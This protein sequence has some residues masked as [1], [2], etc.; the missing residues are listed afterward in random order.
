MKLILDA[1][2]IIF[3]FI[4]YKFFGL[5]TATKVTIAVAII[6]ILLTRIIVGKFEK[7]TIISALC[8]TILG[9][10][11]LFF[12]NEIFIK[13]KPTAVY[14]ASAVAF[15]VTHFLDKTL[16]E[17]I[18]GHAVDLP[19][20]SWRALNIS[21]CVFFVL[22]GIANLYVVYNF[23]TN[24][25]VNFKLFGTLGLTVLFVIGQSIYMSKQHAAVSKK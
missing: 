10:A 13:W 8:I 22:M 9:G 11:T 17:R 14:W 20:K 5:M 23:A 19:V 15:L 4:C 1:L 25:W 3:F 7:M 12:D 6:Q 21:W 16:A 18:A 24:V 2:P